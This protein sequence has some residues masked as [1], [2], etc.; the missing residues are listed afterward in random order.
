[1]FDLKAT[2]P[3]AGGAWITLEVAL[4]SPAAGPGARHAG[5]PGQALPQVGTRHRGGLHHR[6]SRHPGSGADDA[7]LLRRP[8]AHQRDCTGSTRLNNYLL[9]SNLNQEWVPAAGLHRQ[10]SPF[11]GRG[12]Y[13]RL[14]LSC[15]HDRDSSWRHPGGGQG[16][17]RPPRLRHAGEPG[18]CADPLPQMMRHRPAGVLATTGWYC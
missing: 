5:G 16:E 2:K 1:M 18:V 3:P 9:E 14:H 8:G 17:L 6:H 4:A 12:G 7:A 15:L 11:G 10:I 13:H